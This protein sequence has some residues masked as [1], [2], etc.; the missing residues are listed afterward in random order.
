MS[1]KEWFNRLGAGLLAGLAA[2]LLM[3][4]VILLLRFLFGV[5]TPSELVGD[6][7]AP[8][9]GVNKFLELLGRFGGYNHLKQL[10]VSSVIAGQI[11]VGMIGGLSLALLSARTATTPNDSAN[12]RRGV[13]F[14]MCLVGA[15]WLLS[16]IL[17][18]PT[19]GTHY[20]W[21]RSVVAGCCVGFITLPRS[22]TTVCGTAGRMCRPS[23]RTTVFMS[24]PKTPLTRTLR[25]CSGGSKLPAL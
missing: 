17:L 11:I 21:L 15:L 19:L 13:V 3:T 5:A 23:R 18:W 4:L 7:I 16:I 24:S 22:A 25:L 20:K 9:L 12:S 8:L 6:R 1:G 14:V 10:G 2:G